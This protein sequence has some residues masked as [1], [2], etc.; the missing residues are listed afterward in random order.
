MGFWKALKD[1]V[2]VPPVVEEQPSE[3]TVEVPK[4]IL[5]PNSEELALVSERMNKFESD[6]IQKR[7]ERIEKQMEQ[8]L[9]RVNTILQTQ[10][11]TREAMQAFTTAIEEINHGFESVE[12]ALQQKSSEEKSKSIDI[13]RK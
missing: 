9:F 10:D 4:V 7:L 5:T 13:A 1:S 2:T 11:A 3:Q 12:Y 8:V 6:M